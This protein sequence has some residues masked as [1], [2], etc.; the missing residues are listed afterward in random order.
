MAMMKII[1]S[2]IVECALAFLI[3]LLRPDLCDHLGF[4]AGMFFMFLL[5]LLAVAIGLVFEL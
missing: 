2:Y 5:W 3:F 1:I 4:V